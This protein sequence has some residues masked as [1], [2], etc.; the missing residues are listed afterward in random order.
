MTS[1][2]NP[3]KFL[4]WLVFLF[5]IA[6][7]MFFRRCDHEKPT[8]SNSNRESGVIPVPDTTV[9]VP[10]ETLPL[11]ARKP[12]PRRTAVA[13]D[14]DTVSQSIKDDSLPYVFADPWGGRHFDSVAVR[15]HCLE[16]CAILFSLGDQNVLHHLFTMRDHM[17][18]TRFLHKSTRDD[19]ALLF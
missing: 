11:P 18:K 14:S 16:D 2:T 8:G 19:H 9:A 12:V 3:R 15:L 5:V 13:K 17:T 4:P 6:L 10:M 7:A 1:K